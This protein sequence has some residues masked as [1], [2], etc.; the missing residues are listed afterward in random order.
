V[1]LTGKLPFPS[2]TA[3]EAMLMRLME[4]PKTLAEMRPD[5]AFSPELQAVFDKVLARD[6]NQRY[7]V[8]AD[9]GADLVRAAQAGGVAVPR[10]SPYASVTTAMDAMAAPPATQGVPATRV[11]PAVEPPTL[12]RG[13]GGREAPSA[14]PA[15]A[16][17]RKRTGLMVGISAAA[18]LLAGGTA[19]MLATGGHAPK[20]PVVN[21]DTTSQTT[22]PPVRDSAHDTS[23]T[24]IDRPK[25]KPRHDS[26][27][28]VVPPVSQSES[29]QDAVKRLVKLV[30]QNEPDAALALY[31]SVYP[32]L[33]PRQRETRAE[34]L[35][36][37]GQ[38]LGTLKRQ[39]EA[40][41]AVRDDSIQASGTRMEAAVN[42]FLQVCQ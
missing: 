36:Y 29:P 3:Q 1:M 13:P 16:P 37:K 19:F 18:L 15:A 25:P 12:P 28:V 32:R 20:P 26:S 40:C 21:K 9:F 22:V 8:A 31:D 35:F 5:L 27:H 34:A 14:P 6:M 4:K 24:V 38:A 17:P 7:A 39:R 23:T 41:T 33:D 11:A 10:V 30:D 2:E 42:A